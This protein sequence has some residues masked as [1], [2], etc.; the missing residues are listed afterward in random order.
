MEIGFSSLDSSSLS[1]DEK[2]CLKIE[3]EDQIV[4]RVVPTCANTWD[5]FTLEEEGRQSVNPNAGVQDVLATLRV[6]VG[7]IKTLTNFTLSE[8]EELQRLLSRPS[9]VMRS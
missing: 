9:L 1:C 6:M 8:F 3:D 7:L 5:F 4:V 2:C